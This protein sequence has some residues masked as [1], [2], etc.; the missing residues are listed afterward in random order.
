MTLRENSRVDF[1]GPRRNLGKGEEEG[2]R[3]DYREP[4]GG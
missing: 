4:K 1:P 2:N 3:F